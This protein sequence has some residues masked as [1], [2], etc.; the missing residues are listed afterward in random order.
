MRDT[1]QLKGMDISKAWYVFAI[2]ILG[3]F[4]TLELDL[5]GS[6]KKCEYLSILMCNKQK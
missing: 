3:C 2:H 5:L 4:R 1:S 6:L